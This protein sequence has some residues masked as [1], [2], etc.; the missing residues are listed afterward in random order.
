MPSARP[1]PSRNQPAAIFMPGGYTSASDAPVRK[2]NAM[3]LAPPGATSTAALVSAPT[4]D[5]RNINTRA[6]R[7]SA[8]FATALTSVPA[9]KPA[10]TAIVSHAAWFG[11]MSYSAISR[12]VIAVAENHN[13]MP[14]NCASETTPSIFQAEALAGVG[15]I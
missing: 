2:R 6:L 9:T 11:A 4:T 15:T 1:R 3:T 14:R 12:G 7:T 13:V 8:R 5:P 10:C